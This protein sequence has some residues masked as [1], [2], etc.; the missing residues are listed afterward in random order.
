MILMVGVYADLRSVTSTP[1]HPLAW[2]GAEI[3]SIAM[4]EENIGLK[5]YN[6]LAVDKI[7]CVTFSSPGIAELVMRQAV[8]VVTR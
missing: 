1:S 8:D 2:L 5:Q 7:I 6:T 4:F 3:I